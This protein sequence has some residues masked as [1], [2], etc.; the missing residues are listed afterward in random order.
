MKTHRK[1][2]V[3]RSS[4]SH[5]AHRTVKRQQ[6][7]HPAVAAVAVSRLNSR[8]FKRLQGMVLWLRERRGYRWLAKY[9][10]RGHGWWQQV[11]AGKRNRVA[12][13]HADLTNVQRL[14]EIM[15]ADQSIDSEALIL[16]LE[17]VEARSQMDLA[18]TQ[19][20]GLVRKRAG[21]SDE[22]SSH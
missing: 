12:P 13:N 19:L 8:E 2:T 9:T 7:Q 1:P 22:T 11:G 14:Y 3:K 20:I 16:L 21:Q 18:L 15:Q 4:K 10:G 5:I 6:R 17:V